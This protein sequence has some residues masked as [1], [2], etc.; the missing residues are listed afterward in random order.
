M[1]G[2]ATPLPRN[3]KAAKRLSKDPPAIIAWFFRTL[4]S[5]GDS[6]TAAWLP[7]W[8][9]QTGRKTGKSIPLRPRSGEPTK[10]AGPA[11]SPPKKKIKNQKRI[12]RLIFDAVYWAIVTISTV[13]YGDIEPALWISKAFIITEILFGVGFVLLLITMLISVYIDIHRKKME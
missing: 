8:R 7:I 1:G 2:T 3:A 12:L 5:N 13:G 11:K 9:P 6:E 10:T 4:P